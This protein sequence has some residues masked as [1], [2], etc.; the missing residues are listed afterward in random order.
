LIDCLNSAKNAVKSAEIKLEK[1]TGKPENR[2]YNSDNKL[3]RRMGGDNIIS[4]GMDR[5]KPISNENRHGIGVEHSESKCGRTAISYHITNPHNSH[6]L[7]STIGAIKTS[8]TDNSNNNDS[9]KDHRPTPSVASHVVSMDGKIISGKLPKED[10]GDETTKMAV[11]DKP[12][13]GAL[14][15]M[16]CVTKQPTR[17]DKVKELNQSTNKLADEDRVRGKRMMGLMMNHLRAAKNDADQLNKSTKLQQRHEVL[18]RV[19]QQEVERH[20][21][22]MQEKQKLLAQKREALQQTKNFE[23]KCRAAEAFNRWSDN[24]QKMRNHIRTEIKPYVFYKP[25]VYN[26]LLKQR[27]ENSREN[28]DNEI[29]TRKNA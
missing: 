4:V 15:S 18:S 27:L 9:N 16:V 22:Y 23:T 17:S 29:R 10:W 3:K 8:A 28:L 5:Y 25:K 7:A 14:P 6:R 20:A 2:D 24:V 12:K 11:G 13:V 1:Y 19:S 21:D 26:D